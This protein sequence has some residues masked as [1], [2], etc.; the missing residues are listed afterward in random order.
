MNRSVTARMPE[1]SG[2]EAAGFPLFTI[3][4]SSPARQATPHPFGW[5]PPGL[6]SQPATR[7][8][9]SQNLAREA[10]YGATS[11]G[12]ADANAT[13]RPMDLFYFIFLI[14]ATTSQRSFA[15]RSE[16]KGGM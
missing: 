11:R 13:M 3:R 4:I 16:R 10:R 15:V 14:Y 12:S 9:D 7:F 2:S 6:L 8:P 5:F 1:R